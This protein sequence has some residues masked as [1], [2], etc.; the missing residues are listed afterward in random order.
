MT[1]RHLSA[2]PLSCRKRRAPTT[3]LSDELI[4]SS[5]SEHT[6]G[7]LASISSSSRSLSS[8]QVNSDTHPSIVGRTSNGNCDTQ[9]SPA[10]SSAQ[11]PILVLATDALDESNSML[12]SLPITTTMT[13]NIGPVEL[14][15]PVNQAPSHDGT[16]VSSLFFVVMSFSQ[17]SRSCQ[18]TD[19]ASSLL[20][21]MH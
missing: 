17:A 1:K 20:K 19:K 18:I 10:L 8:T 9:S 2:S 5:E 12:A 6:P 7:L 13:T 11:T 14:L 4:S 15:K 3:S 16:V 21:Q